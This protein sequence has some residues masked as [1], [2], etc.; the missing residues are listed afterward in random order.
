MD[1][2]GRQRQEQAVEFTQVNEHRNQFFNTASGRQMIFEMASR[3][4][5]P[6]KTCS[7]SLTLL[8]RARLSGFIRRFSCGLTNHE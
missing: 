1:A 5:V 4:I 2:G 3:K 8:V 6:L 7:P